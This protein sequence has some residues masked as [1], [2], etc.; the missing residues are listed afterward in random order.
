MRHRS[1]QLKRAGGGLNDQHHLPRAHHPASGGNGDPDRWCGTHAA[2]G[3]H[4]CARPGRTDAGRSA[5]IDRGSLPGP[6]IYPSGALIS[7]TSGRGDLQPPHERSRRFFGEVSRG[8]K[9]GANFIADGR[10]EVLTATRENLR[11]GASQIMVMAG[12][13]AASAYD[14][15]DVTQYTLDE[16]KAAVDAAGDW[17][18]YVTGACLHPEGCAARRGGWREMRRALPAA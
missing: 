13:G 10:D 9:L 7:Q 11:A 5:A 3:L 12:G 4:E 14:P 8:E 6:R 2:A 17:G 18:T 15:L 1:A 16:R